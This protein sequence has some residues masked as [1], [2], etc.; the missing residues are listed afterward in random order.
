[1]NTS[2]QHGSAGEKKVHVSHEDEATPLNNNQT[3]VVS[4]DDDLIAEEE[5]VCTPTLWD[6][7]SISG[8]AAGSGRSRVVLALATGLALL[9]LAGASYWHTPGL[10]SGPLSAREIT[11][12]GCHGEGDY[13]GSYKNKYLCCSKEAK[14]YPPDYDVCLCT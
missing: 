8:T 9:M 14:C 10:A 12:G 3:V 2:Y 1:M 13:I 6:A 11:G 7:S 4:E 5:G